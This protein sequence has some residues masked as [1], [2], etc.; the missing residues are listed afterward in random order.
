LFSNLWTGCIANDEGALDVQTEL[1]RELEGRECGVKDPLM[2][3]T[4]IMVT[5]TMLVLAFVMIFQLLEIGHYY[6]VQ[7]TS[8]HQHRDRG[9]REE[10]KWMKFLGQSERRG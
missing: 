1:V 5:V 3:L 8:G 9:V 10:R 7:C 6:G 4:L 2:P